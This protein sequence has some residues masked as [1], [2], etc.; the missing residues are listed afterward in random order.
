[1]KRKFISDEE[2]TLEFQVTSMCDILTTLLLFFIATATDEV[3][4]QTA[5]LELPPAPEAMEPGEPKGS[6][7]VNIEKLGA[8][9][10]KDQ[11]FELT[12]VG[13]VIQKYKQSWEDN[14]LN[15]GAPFRVIIRADKNTTYEK[16][17]EVMKAAAGVGILDVIFSAAESAEGSA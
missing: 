5:D 17:R 13:G 3:S 16:I 4:Q 14:P 15:T 8:L 12:E 10:I 9:K 2:E 6:I 7:T 11:V 1:M